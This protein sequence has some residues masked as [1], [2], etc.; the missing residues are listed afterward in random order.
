[1]TGGG[2]RCKTKPKKNPL[3]S[4]LE[5]TWQKSSQHDRSEIGLFGNSVGLAKT[6]FVN[7]ASTYV[8]FLGGGGMGGWV[9]R[10]FALASE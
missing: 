10:P 8:Y 3:A 1:M 6:D 4:Y 9:S 7:S 5:N 2:D